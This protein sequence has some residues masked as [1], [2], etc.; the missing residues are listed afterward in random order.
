MIFI[1]FYLHFENIW[2][3]SIENAEV[4][5]EYTKN[6]KKTTPKLVVEKYS[7]VESPL[8]NDILPIPLIRRDKIVKI[9]IDLINHTKH[10]IYHFI[11]FNFKY[12]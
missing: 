12:S 6:V 7:L 9:I 10:T 5:R 3:K 2:A 8:S 11:E 4:W 1:L